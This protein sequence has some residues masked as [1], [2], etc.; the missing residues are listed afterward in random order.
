MPCIFSRNS[1]A[2]SYLDK[3]VWFPVSCY[4]NAASLCRSAG[5]IFCFWGAWL[6]SNIRILIYFLHNFPYHLLLLESGTD[7]KIVLLIFLS[8]LNSKKPHKTAILSFEPIP[9]S[10]TSQ[11]VNNA[12]TQIKLARNCFAIICQLACIFITGKEYFIS[13]SDPYHQELRTKYARL[14][15]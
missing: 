10:A 13:N 6:I 4:T 12:S 15:T 7:K 9:P 5:K 1:T 8:K 2:M 3:V 14:A 11:V